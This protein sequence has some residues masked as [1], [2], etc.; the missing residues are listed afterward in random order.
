MELLRSN[1]PAKLY[2]ER[3]PLR[4]GKCS[5]IRT[6]EYE[7]W[8]NLNGQIKSIRGLNIKKWPHLAEEQSR[9]P[10]Y[11]YLIQRL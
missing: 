11:I 5:Y 4:Y 6:Q 9:L 1:F 2:K 10:A 3:F 8:F 7:F